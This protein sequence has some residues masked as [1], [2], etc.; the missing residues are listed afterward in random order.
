M[1]I[2]SSG[3]VSTEQ[4]RGIYKHKQSE[5]STPESDPQ[6]IQANIL[7]YIRY[8]LKEYI[9]PEY[10]EETTE[11]SKARRKM[12]CSIQERYHEVDG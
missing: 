10:M 7:L 3:Y 6:R 5:E 9:H 4:M 1:S 11:T 12:R 2:Q 8:I